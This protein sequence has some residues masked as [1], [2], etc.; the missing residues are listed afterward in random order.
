MCF[1]PNGVQPL[2]KIHIVESISFV[3]F[4]R[5]ALFSSDMW[6]QLQAR[7]EGTK[8]CNY[9]SY[10]MGGEEEDCANSREK[11]V[12]E[13][14]TRWDAANTPDFSSN[15]GTLS[16]LYLFSGTLR[17]PTPPSP[18]SRLGPPFPKIHPLIVIIWNDHY[19]SPPQSKPHIS[20]SHCTQDPVPAPQDNILLAWT[21]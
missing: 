9:L 7:R 10:G 11:M 15:V 12:P 3:N 20:M 6:Q 2:K 4:K 13:E 16:F 18:V 17:W 5:D 19:C 8:T 21:T 1:S 14:G